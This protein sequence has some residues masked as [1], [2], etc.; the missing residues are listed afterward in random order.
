VRYSSSGKSLRKELKKKGRSSRM[1]EE[2]LHW[3]NFSQY[4]RGV[5]EEACRE[6]CRQ[7]IGGGNAHSLPKKFTR[8]EGGGKTG[9]WKKTFPCRAQKLLPTK[10]PFHEIFFMSEVVSR[11]WHQARKKEGPAESTEGTASRGK[12]SSVSYLSGKN[13]ARGRLGFQKKK[14]HKRSA[15]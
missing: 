5:R 13:A 2:K 10:E 4:I 3:K 8:Q 1:E 15:S 14:N 12:G 9:K 6:R 11:T 7:R